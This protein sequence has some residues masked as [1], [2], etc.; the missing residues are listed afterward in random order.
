MIIELT[1]AVQ[2]H[3]SYDFIVD[4]ISIEVDIRVANMSTSKTQVPELRLSCRCGTTT[5]AHPISHLITMATHDLN[6]DTSVV[7]AIWHT[8]VKI[9]LRK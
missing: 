4:G 6:I 1:W 9:I 7:F 3:K 2:N 8:C 5:T